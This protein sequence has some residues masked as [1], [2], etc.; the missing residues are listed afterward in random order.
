[1]STTRA[2]GHIAGRV[3]RGRGRRRTRPAGPCPAAT[4]IALERG[5]GFEGRPARRQIR[6]LLRGACLPPFYSVVQHVKVSPSVAQEEHFSPVGPFRRFTA[7]VSAP[8]MNNA[9]CQA[10]Y[11][12]DYDGVI[13]P[14]LSGVTISFPASIV[15]GGTDARSLSN[16]LPPQVYKKKPFLIHYVCSPGRR[17]AVD[18]NPVMRTIRKDY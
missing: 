2:W 1:M 13:Q 18:T 12:R 16:S 17:G 4:R 3:Q 15:T 11:P 8:V 5:D 6:K 9:Q 10:Q 7:R 14:L